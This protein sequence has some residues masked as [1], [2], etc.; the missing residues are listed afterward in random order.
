MPSSA[1]LG[2]VY[3][4]RFIPEGEA[5]GY[6]GAFFA[7]RA[8]AG[9]AAL[10]LAG[11]LVELAGTYRVVLFGGLAA[12]LALVPLLLAE[13]RRTDGARPA[14]GPP[15]TVTAVIPLHASYAFAGVAREALRHVDDVVLVND[16]GPPALGE[17]ACGFAAQRD[18]VQVL[19][20]A[21]NVGKGSAVAFAVERVL[22]REH[23]P[24][25]VLV[26]D[27][28][29]QHPAELIPAFLE[30]SR[31]AGV[32]IGDRSG[33][34]R[35][36]PLDRRVA[37]GA[38]TAA[39]S[40]LSRRRVRDSQNGMRLY[41]TETLRRVPLPA[42]RYEAETG[43]LRRL[44]GAGERVA[45][46][47]MPAVYRGEPSSFRPLADSLRVAGALV[48]PLRGPARPASAGHGRAVLAE[49]GRWTPRLLAGLAG[50]LAVGVAL[51]VFDGADAALF[52]SINGL[53]DGP[54]WIYQALDPHTRNYGLIVLAAAA[55]AAVAVARGRARAG[56]I[57]GG[58]V[59]VTASA[60]VSDLFLEV[61]QVLVDR[62]RPEE[63]LGEGILL[64]H[65]R[66][67][68]HI[69]SFPSGHLIVTT[70]M[71]VTAMAVAPA[72]R[73]LLWTYVAAVAFTR[74]LFGAHYPLDV[75]VGAAF[76]YEAGLFSVALARASGLLPAAVAERRWLP[77]HLRP[78]RSA[79]AP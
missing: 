5:G 1:T 61:M 48:A 50:V 53:G 12:L 32:V 14:A 74:V 28:D 25:A 36:M 4:A 10:P 37:N 39:L 11:L 42:G 67:W 49:V 68:A 40:A 16:G 56:L 46:V 43:H 59:A 52:T 33:D 65:E 63:A 7:T 22:A 29:G 27:S 78:R 31:G 60:F 58:A 17:A 45:W 71:A 3:F 54:E 77:A 20:L 8:V 18:D 73:P 2:F 70:A 26:L 41:R 69:P 64:S 62:P 57:L 6:S 79:A 44:L 72:L 13:R 76:G 30:A 38:A 23:A 51:P 34:R 35:G 75:L 19:Q 66:T 47:P 15:R 21:E 9:A 55:M 24:E